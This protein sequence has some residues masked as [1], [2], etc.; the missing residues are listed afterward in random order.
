MEISR[1]AP[2]STFHDVR[3]IVGGKQN[4]RNAD[5]ALNFGPENRTRGSV[6]GISVAATS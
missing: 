4:A 5:F 1:T 2:I 6:G 3:L